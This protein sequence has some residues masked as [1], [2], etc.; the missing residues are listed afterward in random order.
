[1]GRG[2]GGG[3]GT[4]VTVTAQWSMVIFFP[5][6]TWRKWVA[7]YVS[8]RRKRRNESGSTFGKDMS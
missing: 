7:Q 3:G 4:Y 5:V 8:G 2:G 6:V 1:V